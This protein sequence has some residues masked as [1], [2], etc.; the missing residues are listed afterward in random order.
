MQKFLLTV[1]IINNI[2]FQITVAILNQVLTKIKDDINNIDNTEESH[3]IK[4]HFSNTLSHLKL[5]KSEFCK[6]DP[7]FEELQ[8]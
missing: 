4:S 2:L 5:R 3:Q 6:K 7:K 1:K 8:I